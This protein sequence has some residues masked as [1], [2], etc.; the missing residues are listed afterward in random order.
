[1]S[2]PFMTTNLATMMATA[3]S[4]R[5]SSETYADVEVPKVPVTIS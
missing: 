5:T 3:V 2:Q 1:M 4:P